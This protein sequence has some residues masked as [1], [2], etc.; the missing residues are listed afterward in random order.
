MSEENEKKETVTG[1]DKEEIFEEYLKPKRYKP[2]FWVW[3]T[4]VIS[5]I[6]LVIV[7]KITVIDTAINPEELKP[8]IEIFNLD[9]Q[10]VVLEEIDTKEFKGIVLVP[11]ISFQVRNIGNVVLRNVYFLGEFRLLDRAKNLGE[12]SQMAFRKP[13]NPGETSE[14]IVLTCGAGYRASSKTAFKNNIKEWK[15]AMVEI[16]VKTGS[17]KLIFLKIFYITRKIE[18]L[19]VDIKLTDKSAEELMG[20]QEKKK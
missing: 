1:E 3:V 12:G 2:R 8:S 18:G 7:Y 9:S 10:W 14:R 11:Q 13:L 17:S 6:I 20:E 5:A 19:D 4:L 16:Y 15:R